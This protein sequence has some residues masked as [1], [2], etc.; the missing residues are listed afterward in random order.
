VAVV[1]ADAKPEPKRRLLIPWSDS[2]LLCYKLLLYIQEAKGKGWFI[3]QRTDQV[4]LLVNLLV[5]LAL[6]I[7]EHPPTHTCTLTQSQDG[8]AARDQKNV[9]RKP[10]KTDSKKWKEY[11]CQKLGMDPDI[12]EK[13]RGAFQSPQYTQGDALRNQWNRL[14]LM[15]D[16]YQKFYH[17]GK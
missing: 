9:T 1:L 10:T 17:S 11:V 8:K 3:V 4:F 6:L 16:V 2:P 13:W 7:L 15:W 14:R 12:D 5:H